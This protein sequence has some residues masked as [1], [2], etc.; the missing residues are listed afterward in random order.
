MIEYR[1]KLFGSKVVSLKTLIDF[2]VQNQRLPSWIVQAGISK[3][4]QRLIVVF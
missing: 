1:I 2:V 3:T 4:N